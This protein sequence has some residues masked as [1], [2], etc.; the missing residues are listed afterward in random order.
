MGRPRISRRGWLMGRLLSAL[1]AFNGIAWMQAWNLTYYAPAGT[2]PSRPPE[3][4]SLPERAWT[5]L[6]G[7][8]VPRPENTAPLAAGVS[9]AVP[10]PYATARIPLPGGEWLEVWQQ[11]HPAAQG[12]VLLFPG[13]A[14]SKLSLLHPAA[15]FYGLGYSVILADY[16][17]VGGSSGNDTTLGVREG[18][19][20]A[21]V[22]AYA[23]QAQPDRPILLYGESLGAAAILRAVAHEGVQPD[24]ILLQAPFNRL[25]DTVSNRFTAMGLPAFPAAQT[26]VFWGSVQQGMNGFADNPVEYA[27]AVRCPTLLLHGDRDPRVTVAQTAEIYSALGGPKTLVRFP[28]AGHESLYSADSARWEAAVHSFLASLPTP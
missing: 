26:L 2:M 9:A 27:A 28:P 22:V 12:T 5:I 20:V 13:Y 24:A 4:L 15:A 10:L 19:D 1:L 25:V 21:A 17:G 18:A 23:W 11:A 6:T 16:R 14:M 3:Q 8:Q 7:V